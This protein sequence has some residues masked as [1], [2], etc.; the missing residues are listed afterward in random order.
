M[1]LNWIELKRRRKIKAGFDVKRDKKKSHPLIRLYKTTKRIT[2]STQKGNKMNKLL[3][4][5]LPTPNCTSFNPSPPKLILLLD[6]TDLSP[7]IKFFL[8]WNLYF[9]EAHY[10]FEFFVGSDEVQLG[11]GEKGKSH[12]FLPRLTSN[13]QKPFFYFKSCLYFFLTFSHP[14]HG[15]SFKRRK[16]G[17]AI[18][19]LKSNEA[20]K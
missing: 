15:R 18:F 19:L 4:T 20:R 7:S 1:H 14:P 10:R 8:W 3:Y 11:S 13:L 6:C 2:S 12:F 9:I 16:K 5:F 17:Q